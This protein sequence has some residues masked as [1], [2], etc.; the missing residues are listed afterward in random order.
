M[1][2][3]GPARSSTKGPNFPATKHFPATFALSD[4]FYQPKE[5]SRDK[6]E[7]LLRLDLSNVPPNPGV[8]V[9][10]ATIPLAW[11]KTYGKGRVFYS[12]ART[13][14]RTLGHPRRAADVF[15]SDPVGARPHRRRRRRRSRCRRAGEHTMTHIRVGRDSPC[16]RR[17][18]EL[19]VAVSRRCRPSAAQDWPYRGG[20]RRRAA[21]LAAHADHPGQRGSR[22]AR[23][24]P[25]MS[26]R[27]TCRSRRSWSNGVMYLS[28]RLEHLRARARDRE[29]AVEVRDSGAGRP[30]RPG[31]LAGR[32]QR[33]RASCKGAGDRLLALDAKSGKPASEFGDVGWV[34]LKLGIKGDVDGRISMQSPPA[35]Y[36]NIII[37]GGNNG[38]NSPSL[39]LYGDI[40]GWDARTGKLLWTFHTVPRPGEPGI[41]TWEGEQ[42]EESIRHQRLVLLHGRHRA[43][44]RLR[45]HRRADVGLLRRRSQGQ[46]PLRQLRRRARR[47]DR[48]S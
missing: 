18:Y 46:Q 47:D 9:R 24:G 14:R 41:E 44:A 38:E 29:G 42:L 25:S 40:R 10:T 48:R 6:V 36:K 11:A 21:I 19:C 1:E 45:P 31:L 13:R 20:D 37:T 26:G 22:C 43:R 8:H 2:C 4:E 7:V 3:G 28:R 5:F 15:R 32:R 39:G 27:R 23:P 33:V 17:S 35:V 16:R 12:V 30:S 34:D